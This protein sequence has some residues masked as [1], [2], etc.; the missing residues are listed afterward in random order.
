MSLDFV[1]LGICIKIILLLYLQKEERRMTIKTRL[2]HVTGTNT[3]V[4]LDESLEAVL[5]QAE[6]SDEALRIAS[7][8]ESRNQGFDFEAIYKAYPRK[9]SKASGIKWLKMNVRSRTRYDK[10]LEAVKNY[11]HY[12]ADKQMDEQFVQHFSTWVRRFEDWTDENYNASKVSQYEI[13]N[14]PLQNISIEKLLG[15]R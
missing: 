10:L 2:A 3:Y 15:G 13:I 1:G 6:G 4:I 7:Q 12:V 8:I 9:I 5:G 14:Q 11:S